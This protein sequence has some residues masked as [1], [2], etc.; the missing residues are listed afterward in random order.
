[1]SAP[2][3][4]QERRAELLDAWEQQAAGW[5][6]QADR[7]QDRALPV[8]M[9][10]IEHLG[11][12]P[13]ERVLELAAGP[14]D[15]GFLAAEQIRPGG[16]LICSDGSEAMLEL[17]RR[18]A[19]EQGIGNVEFR[20][21]QLEWIDLPTAAVDAVLCRWGVMLCLDPAAALMECR[22]VL[23]PGG[24]AAFAVWDLP[25]SNPW[26]A[27]VTSTLIEMELTEPPASADGAPGMFALSAPGRIEQLLEEAGFV[28]VLVE[29]V[30]I[31]R[32]YDSV[33]DWIGETLDCSMMFARVWRELPGARRRELQGLL[34]ERAAA[35]TDGDG[36]LVLPGRCLCARGGA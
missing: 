5:G 7:L 2:Q 12:Q 28:E 19:A 11:L 1:M 34:A 33:L 26:T 6:R 22:R 9:W 23:R 20:R 10:L 31:V 32:R 14:G 29:P 15:T 17:A 13:G 30:V 24:R 35:F 4:P 36:S 27:I 8:S 16:T 18:R 21:L 3:D 25:E